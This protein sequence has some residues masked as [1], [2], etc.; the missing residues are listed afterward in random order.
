MNVL[1]TLLCCC[2]FYFNLQ[3]NDAEK[4]DKKYVKKGSIANISGTQTGKQAKHNIQSNFDLYKVLDNNETNKS[5]SDFNISNALSNTKAKDLANEVNSIARSKKNKNKVNEY[6]RYFLDDK[7]LHL[8]SYMG[9][10]KDTVESIENNNFKS[11][12]KNQYLN[13]DERLIIAIS[14]SVPKNVLH[15]YFDAFANV[16]YD[17]VF[18]MNGLVNNNPKYLMPTMKYIGELLEARTQSKLV[19][20]N[21]Y[22]LEVDINPKIFMKYSIEKVPAVIF[23]KNYNEYAE[24]QG[25]SYS[26]EKNNLDS[27]DVYIAYGDSEISYVLNKINKIAKSKGLERLV[28]AMKGHNR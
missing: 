5:I 15:R 2:F 25:K 17:V 8:K 27:E 24:L 16:P 7:E 20:D 9:K 6:K 26:S 23:V 1:T 3:A 11:V 21:K 10:Y 14:S 18:V 12:S 22:I 19:K 13:H 4:L 28:K